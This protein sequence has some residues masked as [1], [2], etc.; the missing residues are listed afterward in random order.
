[1]DMK[2]K[3]SAVKSFANYFCVTQGT[4]TVL[5]DFSLFGFS[6][7]DDCEILV[8]HILLQHGHCVYFHK[9]VRT[10]ASHSEATYAHALT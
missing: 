4:P 3:S 1:M 7:V 9:A 2:C 8:D 6:S 10:A 5:F